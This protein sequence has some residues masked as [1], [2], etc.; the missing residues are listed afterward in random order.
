MN[1]SPLFN[2][3][4]NI[5]I[6]NFFF[7]Y[8]NGLLPLI[9]IIFLFTT[10]PSVMFHSGISYRLW[11]FAGAFLALLGQFI[12][13]FT[14]GYEYIER[15]GR[16]GKVFASFLV[17]GGVYAH[18][19]NPM[20]VGNISIAIGL[21]MYGGSPIAC[22]I[23]IPFFFFFYQ[24]IIAA[25]ENFLRN[26]FGADYENYCRSVNRFFPPV[27][28]LLK[29]LSPL[30][31]DWKRSLRKEY[32]TVFVVVM[33]L[34]WLPLW[35][36]YYLGTPTSFLEYRSWAFGLSLF[37]LVLYLTARFLKKAKYLSSINS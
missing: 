3:R 33:G 20:Y 36:L 6:G 30:A 31:F 13:L 11:I 12:R 17:Q 28:P 23:G 21:L 19:R 9:Y 25:E 2:S 26:K 22:L 27:H 29:T 37:S 16:E 32:G 10:S 7:R 34:I 18:T 5:A 35:R 24:S 1:L 4:F 8:R 15:G 14:I